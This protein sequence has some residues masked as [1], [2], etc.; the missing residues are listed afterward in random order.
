L[1]ML[2][3]TMINQRLIFISDYCNKMER[4][5]VLSEDEFIGSDKAAAAESYLRRSI[6]AMFD[7]GRHILAKSGTVELAQEYKS[8]AKGLK[9][10]EVVDENLGETMI[11]IAGYRN[12]MVHMYNLISDEEVYSIIKNELNDLKAFVKQV[13]EYINKV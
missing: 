2:N 9:K 8:I 13:H 11:R 12:R 4:L 3:K 1:K 10:L 6:E 7:I 5:S